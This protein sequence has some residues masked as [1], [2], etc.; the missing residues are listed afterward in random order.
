MRLILDEN[1]HPHRNTLAEFVA[2][3]PEV[4]AVLPGAPKGAVTVVSA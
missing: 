3:V 2:L 4:L 1:L